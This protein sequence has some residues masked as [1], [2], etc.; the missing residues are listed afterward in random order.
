MERTN[1]N[2]TPFYHAKHMRHVGY[3]DAE[4]CGPR[5]FFS[6][7][8]VDIISNKITQLLQGV[9]PQNRIIHVPDN[10]IKSVMSSV[11]DDYR[12]E[13]GDIHSRYTMSRKTSPTNVVSDL[14]DQTIE[15]I[16]TDIKNSIEIEEN[17]KKL[18]VWTT[19]MGDFNEHGLQQHSAIKIRNKHPTHGQFNMNY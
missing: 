18:T 6:S 14:V 9:D 2:N 5:A 19:L 15:L 13:I 1:K 17:N 4:E 16:V 3:Y 10:R 8:T 7:D 12:P 11:H